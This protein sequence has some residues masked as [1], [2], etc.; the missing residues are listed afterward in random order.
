[1]WRGRNVGKRTAMLR[2]AGI[3]TAWFAVLLPLWLL[4]VGMFRLDILIAGIVAAA[5]A[6]AAAVA[7]RLAGLFEFAVSARVVATEGR[8]AL[9]VYPDFVK[10]VVAVARCGRRPPGRFR[11]TDYPYE[12]GQSPRARGDR[13]VV[14]TASSLAPSSYV[15]H[16]DGDRGRMLVHDLGGRSSS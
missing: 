13:A 14:T 1:V 16:I 6:A 12:T 11:W 10:I 9:R 15:I 3:W 4:Y 5:L 7:V 8:A 2:L